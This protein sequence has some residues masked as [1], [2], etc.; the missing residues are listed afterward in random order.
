MMSPWPHSTLPL[1]VDS[2]ERDQG[3][4]GDALGQAVISDD[5]G[6]EPLGERFQRLHAA[7]VGA[8]QQ[9]RRGPGIG[10]AVGQDL[11]L[12]PP[13][14]R[15]LADRRRRQPRAITRAALAWRMTKTTPIAEV[16]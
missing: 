1:G 8:G 12:Q 3:F 2:Y 5:L 11:G 14:L 9:H 4:E 13:V 7:H 6:A 15:Q 10:Q 16:S